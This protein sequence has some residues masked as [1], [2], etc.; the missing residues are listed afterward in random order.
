[1]EAGDRRVVEVG[2]AAAFVPV[3]SVALE[4]RPGARVR[5]A[6]E[7][8]HTASGHFWLVD[9]EG[10][11]G[12]AGGNVK[13]YA[14][15]GRLCHVLRGGARGADL[16]DPVSATTVHGS[17][18]AVLDAGAGRVSLY[19]AR[20]RRQ[21]GFDVP[22]VDEP[23]QIRNLGDQHLAVVGRGGGDRSRRLV[24]L[25]RLDGRYSESVFAAAHRGVREARGFAS[26]SQDVHACPVAHSAATGRCLLVA[27]GP[28][29]SVT[30]YDFETRL[31]HSFPCNQDARRD[32]SALCGL[33]A[34]ASARVVVMYRAPGAVPRYEYA[35]YTLAG[36]LILGNVHSPQRLVGVEGR[37]FYSIGGAEPEGGLTLR[38]CRLRELSEAD[39]R[40]SL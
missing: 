29:E 26:A 36:E 15:E 2:F 35:L 25:Y 4:E 17:W 8:T 37:L 16:C 7:A 32:G 9:R 39:T 1:M 27:Y 22:Q 38:V 34:A 40:K 21:G 19:D 13:I 33:F 10:G 3:R 18:V 11:A 30:Q 31:V 14:P 24:H 23:R 6:E 20:A 12:G 5:S 28:T